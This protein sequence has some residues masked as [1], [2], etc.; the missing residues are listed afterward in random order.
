VAAKGV[1]CYLVICPLGF[2][3]LLTPS[4]PQR[5]FLLCLFFSSPVGGVL[6]FSRERRKVLK[7]KSICLG[8]R[9]SPLQDALPYLQ[10]QEK[11]QKRERD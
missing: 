7:E 1:T 2:F 5:P 3:P 4:S 10:S 8:L 9:S 6:D 11:F